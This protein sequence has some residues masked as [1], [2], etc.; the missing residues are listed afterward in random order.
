MSAA[1]LGPAAAAAP[2]PQAYNPAGIF[3]DTYNDYASA[4]DITVN[5]SQ[6]LEFYMDCSLNDVDFLYVDVT[7]GENLTF[8]ISLDANASQARYEAWLGGE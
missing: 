5:R 2:T 3:N 4:L 7:A 6:L 8:H 1:A